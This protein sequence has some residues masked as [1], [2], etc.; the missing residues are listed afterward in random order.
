MKKTILLTLLIFVSFNLFSNEEGIL[1]ILF[2]PFKFDTLRISDQSQKLNLYTGFFNKFHSIELNNSTLDKKLRLEPNGKTSIGLGF[3]YKWIGLSA[4]FSPGFLNKDDEIYGKTKSFDT[5]INLYANSFGADAY[6]Q[7]YKGFYMKNPDNFINWQNDEYPFRPDLESYAFGLSTFYFTN[8]KKFSY[9]AAFT[10]TQIQK[11]SAGSFMAGAYFTLN[12]ANIP[13]GL[14]PDELP[15][16]LITYYNIEGY[17]TGSIGVSAG[18]TYTLVFFKRFFINGSLV[19]GLGIRAAEFRANDITNKQDA[20]I[21]ASVTSRLAL[22]YEGKKLYAGIRII[23]I[24]DSYK[25]E[26]VDISSSSGNMRFYIGKRFNTD[27]WFK[28]K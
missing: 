22:G 8:N 17:K 20:S 1:N 16:S 24:V 21:T 10:R 12:N 23:S 27:N 14:V 3:N 25:Y 15:D 9:K 5:Q 19:P 6:L 11:K 2:K 28:K 18:Y 26:S 4:S 7:Y 13:N